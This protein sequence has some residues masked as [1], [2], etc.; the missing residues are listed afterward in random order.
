[1]NYTQDD[2]K[3]AKIELTVNNIVTEKLADVNDTWVKEKFGGEGINDLKTLESKMSEQMKDYKYQNE[4]VRVVDEYINKAKDS[5]DINIPT[6]IIESEYNNR[7]DSYIKRF[8]SKE[9][10]EKTILAD[11]KGQE[12]IE[13]LQAEIKT[14]SKTS[15]EKFFIFQ[16]LIELFD[17]KDVKWDQELDAEKKL[18]DHLTK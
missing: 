9:N 15:L 11:P 6:T 16:K 12:M 7:Y 17:I 2:N 10:F 13:K 18:Y 8:G 5:F 4:L 3:P 1:M 14:A